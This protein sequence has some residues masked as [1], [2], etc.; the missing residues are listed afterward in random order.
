LRVRDTHR[1][2]VRRHDA[3]FAECSLLRLV[4]HPLDVATYFGA[5]VRL[6]R[7][8]ARA[9]ILSEYRQHLMTAHHR[10]SRHRLS[11]SRHHPT[12]VIGIAEAEQE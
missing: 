10:E 4:G 3:D 1:A 9:L 8:R 2:A 12:L 11:E 5:K 7:R 6:R